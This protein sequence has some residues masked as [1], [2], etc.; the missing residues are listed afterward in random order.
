MLEPYLLRV[1]AFLRAHGEEN[2]PIT[3][4]SGSLPLTLSPEERQAVWWML[5]GQNPD[6]ADPKGWIALGTGLHLAVTTVVEASAQANQSDASDRL[7]ALRAV[8]ANFTEGL[9]EAINAMVATGR[10][11]EAKRL[12]TF[13]NKLQETLAALRNSGVSAAPP[14]FDMAVE[15]PEAPAAQDPL[16]TEALETVSDTETPSVP[17]PALAGYLLRATAFLRA[18]GRDDRPLTIAFGRRTLTVS[19]WERR[20]LWNSLCE[21][22]APAAGWHDLIPQC[23]ALELGM[24]LALDELE[25]LGRS[26]DAEQA[27]LSELQTALGL[28]S[29]VVERFRTEIAGSVASGA[30][31]DAK[32]LSAVR[33]DLA[34]TLV[35]A[36]R[37]VAA[38]SAATVSAGGGGGPASGTAAAPAAS[39]GT[40]TP[41]DNIQ[42]EKLRPFLDRAEQ[43]LTIQGHDDRPLAIPVG[44]RSWSVDGWERQVL[45]KVLCE[46]GSGQPEWAL[47]LAHGAAAQLA[48]LLALERLRKAGEASEGRAAA[49]ADRDVAIELVSATAERLRA[50]SEKL[51]ADGQERLAARLTQF[52]AKLLDSTQLLNRTRG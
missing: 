22:Q 42:L 10:S 43:L 51:A 46:E 13:R 3:I 17:D 20:V 1:G 35:E 44:R 11:E 45:W 38:R 52:R 29:G 49:E 37:A 36:R 27:A 21:G 5:C 7:V 4:P 33:S 18:R 34:A 32:T 25:R 23:V 28:S 6:W 2:R 48:A 24:L 15:A 14:P 39:P 47:R 8:A 16:P 31:E 50:A 41:A 30:V 26:R 40:V 9:R 19:A 12:S